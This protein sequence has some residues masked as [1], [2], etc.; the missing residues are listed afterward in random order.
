MNNPSRQPDTIA[1]LP[2][3]AVAALQRGNK[4]EA[5]KLVREE[6]GLGLKEAKDLVDQYVQSQPALQNQ[7][8]AAQAEKR[9]GCLTWLSVLALL[10]LL[11]YYLLT[12]T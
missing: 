5:I 6:R 4:I 7:I 8:A 3:A 9:R 10:A 11:G 12:K 2:A 1:K